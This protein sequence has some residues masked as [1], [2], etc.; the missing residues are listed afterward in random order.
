M[1]F[2]LFQKEHGG[3]H[4]QNQVSEG[5]TDRKMGSDRHWVCGELQIVNTLTYTLSEIEAMGGF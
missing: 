2:G 5:D 4:D 1:C 3:Q